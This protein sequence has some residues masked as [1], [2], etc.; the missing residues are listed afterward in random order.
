MSSV[1]SASASVWMPIN[2]RTVEQAYT[3]VL[4][5]KRTG[6]DRYQRYGRRAA[7]ARDPKLLVVLQKGSEV[8]QRMSEAQAGQHGFDVGGLRVQHTEFQLWRNAYVAVDAGRSE[9]EAQYADVY[10][11]AALIAGLV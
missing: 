6:V 2:E 9:E 7:K 10:G 3:E 8:L 5:A 4:R 11:M 1:A